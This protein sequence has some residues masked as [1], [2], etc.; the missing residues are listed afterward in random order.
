MN[1]KQA[2]TKLMQNDKN[3]TWNECQTIEELKEGLIEAMKSYSKNEDTFKFYE[4][5]L[6]TLV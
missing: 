1:L 5:I 6:K 4:S 2:I 3:A